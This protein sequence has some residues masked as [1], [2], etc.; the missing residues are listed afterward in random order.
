MNR[1]PFDIAPPPRSIPTSL[2]LRI[3]IGGALNQIGWGL[4]GLGSVLFWTLAANADL[5]AWTTLRGALKHAKGRV[6][7]VEDAGFSIGGNA[8]RH[9]SRRSGRP[10][11]IVHYE[12][13]DHAG[14]THQYRSY[15]ESL[16]HEPGRRVDITYPPD[17]PEISRVMGL[18]AAPL[19]P[20]AALVAIMPLIAL[21]L[22]LL[23]LRRG[24]AVRRLLSRG[25]YADAVVKSKSATNVQINNE[26]VYEFTFE[27]KS[28]DGLTHTCAHRTHVT[29]QITDDATEGIL[30]D[31]AD[32][33]RAHP[34]DNL[35]GDPEFDASGQIRSTGSSVASM[36]L[37]LI[38]II[39]N[40]IHL[41]M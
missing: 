11:R 18:R 20:L 7:R 12:F 33:R 27:F 14:R 26:T 21:I 35:P 3:L 19:P 17:H 38:T 34:I 9:G 2:N 6:L 24:L 5:S 4:L 16:T 1:T 37:P 32:P 28:D 31:P 10:V 30:Y 41:S 25:K 13:T 23:G 8:G 36:I 29:S 15:G 22:V 39:G 40:A